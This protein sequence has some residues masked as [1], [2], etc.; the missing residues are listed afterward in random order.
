MFA[1]LQVRGAVKGPSGRRRLRRRFPGRSVLL[2]DLRR[3]LEQASGRVRIL[4]W[5][6]ILFLF[7][8]ENKS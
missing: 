7:G 6:W 1:F 3:I 2:Q 4:V 8:I 5:I